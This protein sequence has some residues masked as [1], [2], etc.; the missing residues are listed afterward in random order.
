LRSLYIRIWLTV[1]AALALFALASGW[2]L[3]RHLSQERARA[4]ALL[5]ERL[6]GWGPLIQGS[7]PP[8]T[9]SLAEQTAALEDW[10]HRMHTPLA[11]LDAQGK[12]IAASRRYLD[13]QAEG[14]GRPLTVPLE[15]GRKLSIMRP[16][17]RMLPLRRLPPEVGASGPRRDGPGGFPDERPGW[18]PGGERGSPPEVLA[19]GQPPIHLGPVPAGGDRPEADRPQLPPPGFLLGPGGEWP[20]SLGL[21]VLLAMLFIAVAAGAYPAVRSITGRLERLK[22]GVEAFGAG[23]LA[24][25]VQ[26]EGKDEVA[27]LAASFNRAAQQIQSLVQSNQS[28]LANASHELRSPLARLKMALSMINDAG[29]AGPRCARKSRSTSANSMPWWKRC[30]CPAVWKL[31]WPWTWTIRW[32]PWP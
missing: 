20:A 1:I 3:E 15:D 27:A 8:S 9:A 26:E 16:D 18:P 31:V 25:R 21:V 28:L 10:S 17:L 6:A 30:C 13:I 14:H 23:A 32:T 2:L 12:R 4:D 24:Q 29:P 11:L 22:Q 5:S 7:L 19:D